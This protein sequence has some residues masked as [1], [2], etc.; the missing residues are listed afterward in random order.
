MYWIWEI[1]V[2]SSVKGT[3]VYPVHL[4]HRLHEEGDAKSGP[5]IS[6]VLYPLTELVQGNNLARK[7]AL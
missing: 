1:S 5:S 6:L 2:G 7:G 4:I 3:P